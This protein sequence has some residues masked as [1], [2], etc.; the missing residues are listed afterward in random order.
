MEPRTQALL[1]PV[2]ACL[3]LCLVMLRAGKWRPFNCD[4]CLHFALTYSCVLPI[5]QEG[6]KPLA[7]TQAPINP[8]HRRAQQLR[9][10]H[11]IPPPAALLSPDSASSAVDTVTAPPR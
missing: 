2:P 5:P 6:H 10:C 11:A 4:C 7:P 9:G 3:A 8:P 1:C